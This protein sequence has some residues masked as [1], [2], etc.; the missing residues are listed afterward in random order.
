MV[1]TSAEFRLA[2]VDGQCLAW[3]LKRNCSITPVQLAM[4]YGSLC[5]VSLS[6]GLF[7]WWQGAWF[8]FGFAGLELLAVGTAFLVYA[9]HAADRETVSLDGGT[10][11]VERAAGGRVERMEFGCAWGVS[12]APS[13]RRGGLIEIAG[14]GKRVDVGRHVRPEARPALVREMTVALRAASG[15]AP[16]R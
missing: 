12:I 9:R 13:A 1:K 2:R 8:V 6:I 5:A 16:G 4:L 11:I 14:Q 7:F 3:H 10:L 15:T